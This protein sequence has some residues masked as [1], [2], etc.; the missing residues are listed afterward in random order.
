MIVMTRRNQRQL[1]PAT[2][3]LPNADTSL[4]AA[5]RVLFSAPFPPPFFWRTIPLRVPEKL[6]SIWPLVAV[7][8]TQ[9]Q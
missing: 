4:C 6:R 5:W 9:Q 8:T 1:T 7:F 2:R 3:P